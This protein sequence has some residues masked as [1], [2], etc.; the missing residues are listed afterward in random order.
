ME[1][2]LSAASR[3]WDNCDLLAKH[4][5]YQEAAYLAGYVAECSLKALVIEGKILDAP[6][7]RHEIMTLSGDAL[8][9]ALIINP[10][11]RRYPIAPVGSLRQWNPNQRYEETSFLQD[12]DFQMM[13]EEAD[14]I[15]Q[16]IL[17]GLTLDGLLED[18][19]Q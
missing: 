17:I 16:T 11:L 9:L 1:N 18:L 15:A 2:Y 3:H 13:I 4:G 10:L 14:K 12:S 6:K 5:Q 19:P 7:F 8:E